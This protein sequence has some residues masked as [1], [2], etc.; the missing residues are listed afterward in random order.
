MKPRLLFTIVLLWITAFANAQ[1]TRTVGNSGADYTTLKSAFDAVNTGTLRGEITL[2]LIAN[3]TETATASLNA[4]GFGAASY[5][6]VLIYPTVSGV[7]VFGSFNAPL[8]QFFGADNVTIDGRVNGAGSTVDLTLENSNTGS[9]SSAVKYLNSAENT[10]IKYCNLKSACYSSGIGLIQFSSSNVGSGN[11]NNTVEYCNITNSGG[12]RPLNAVFSSG[13]SGRENSENNIRNNNFYDIL[14]PDASANGIM[15]SFLTTNWTVEGNSFYETGTLIPTGNFRYIPIY[16]NTGTHTISNNYIGG[17]APLC[18]GSAMVVN[19]NK[20]HYFCGIFINGGTSAP[21]VVEGNTI[22]NMN[23]TSSDDNPWDGIFINSGNVEV[24]GN[25]I[26]AGIGNGSITVNCD[27]A[28]ATATLSGGSITGLTLL[29]GGSGYTSAPTVTFSASGSSTPATVTATVSGGVVT[30]FTLISGGAGYTSIPS[31]IFDAQSNNYA[32]THG[33]I[34]NSAGTVVIADNTIGS[35]TISGSNY[36]SHGFE[37]IYVR[38]SS[39]NVSI[40]NNLIGSLTTSNSI[41]TSSSAQFSLQK[42]DVYGIYSS[43]VGTTLISGNTVANLTNAYSGTNSVSRTRGILVSAGTNTISDNVVRDISTASAQTGTKSSASVIGITEACTTAGTTQN[44]TGNTIYNLSNT[45]ATA[46]TDIYGIYYAGPN[47]GINTVSGNLIH[48]ISFASSNTGSDVDGIVLFNGLTTCANNI[49][50]LGNGI[51]NGY[52]INGI[53]DDAGATNNNTVCFN[54]VFICGEVSGTTSATAALWN[55]GNAS[56]RMYQNNILCNA[57]TG[58]SGA[59]HYAVYLAGVANLTIN[60]NDYLATGT[61]GMLGKIGN[62]EKPNLNVWKAGTSQ[63][64]NSLNINPIFANAGGNSYTDYYTSEVLPAVFISTITTD[65][66]G[67]IRS[68]NPKMGALETNDY[69]WTGTVSTDFGIPANW[70][71]GSV[72]PAGANISFAV[73]PSNHCILDQNRILGSIT[74]A[75]STY[76]LITNGHELTITKNL[77]FTNGAY[78]DATSSSSIIVFN[79]SELQTIPANAFFNNTIAGL[80]VNNSFGLNL[81]NDFTFSENLTLTSGA[82]N[83]GANTLILN[84]IVSQTSG[85]LTGV[86][87]TNISFG[88]TGAN[89]ILPSVELNNLTINRSNGITLNGNVSVAGTLNLTAGILTVGANSLNFSGKSLEHPEVSM[90]QTAPQRFFSTMQQL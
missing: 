26:G 54:T 46:R 5:T 34:Q 28:V 68:E 1:T 71:Q 16:A 84:G 55:A 19:A 61:S 78:I 45:H 9:F 27:I 58:G 39:R 86:I 21:S 8:V 22:Q 10:V 49:I 72:P 60:Y 23:Y 2:Q 36:F 63:D 32:T 52:K 43:G 53:W 6:S 35:V 30:G 31:V 73:S 87:S 75:Q 65:F 57:R 25:T 42:Q 18:A 14:N 17:S 29:H 66:S 76:N 48:S 64:L 80:V 83:I 37:S 7:S 38:S 77:N 44:I 67:L 40:T 12:N 47:S 69:T 90:P 41:F 82:L 51:S 4:N 33:I 59:K 88:G 24:I 89:T 15:L 11:D 56:T 81:N 50:V 74:N 70:V 13:G 85:T 20:P 79:G 3:T 62:L